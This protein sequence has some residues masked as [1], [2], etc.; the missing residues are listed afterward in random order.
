[1]FY[2]IETEDQLSR[3]HTDCTN[4]FI[5]I[6]PLNDNFH[7]K[8]SETCLIYYKC[9]TSKGYLFTINHSE[10]FKL[11][12][13]S[14]LN[15]L[16]RKHERI[17]TLDKKATKY[18]IGDELPIIDVNFML[19]EA[20]KEEA[21]NTTL[22]DHFYNKFFHLKNVNSIIPISKHYEKQENI[23]DNISWCLGLTPNEYLNND[24]TDVFYNI[25]KQGIGF[26]EKLLRKH[27]E[28]G[29]ADYSVSA[30]RIYGY[31]NLYNQTTRPTNA[32]NNINFSALNKDN[33]ARETFI[34]TND[35]LVEFDYS[36]YHPRIIAKIIGYEWKTNPYDEIPK[37]VMFQN[38]YGG[39]RKEHIQEPFFAKLN[40]Y[41]DSKWYDFTTDGELDLVMTKLRASRIENPT[42]NKI[43]SYIIQSYETYY[44]VQTLKA[45]FD[46]LK[47]KQTKIVLYTYDSFLFDVSRKDGKKLLTDIKD[48][49]E[50]LGFPT[51]MKTGDNY[52]VLN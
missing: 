46:Y 1:M 42:K 34:P 14:V 33:G 31:F 45:V 27:F 20:L 8:L 29:W 17:Y 40:D 23:F 48:M 22:H 37:E 38:L 9:P 21:F 32:F 7:P 2:I 12:L 35:Y 50:N 49:L 11:P 47:D 13:Q 3:L 18:L 39:I 5:N 51:K 15:Y 41:L 43:L 30:S 6:I 36:A 44:N 28:F 26:D 24:Y 4:C 10:A 16:T 52:G 19:P 25:E